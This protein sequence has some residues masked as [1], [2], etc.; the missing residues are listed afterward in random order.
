MIKNEG[1]EILRNFIDK[2]SLDN[3]NKANKNLRINRGHTIEGDYASD[4]KGNEVW[5]NYWT[6]SVKH[7][8]FVQSLNVLLLEQIRFHLDK[9]VMYHA[10]IV[11]TT[12]DMNTIR[13][14]VDTP[15]RFE[16]FAR[17]EKLLGIQCLIPLDNFN[18]DSGSTGFVPYSQKYYFDIKKCYS[19]KYNDYFLDN[20][21]QPDLNYGDVL[22]W[23]PKT[24]HSA[25]PNQTNADRKALLIFYCSKNIEEFLKKIDNVK[26]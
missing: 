6:D 25:I 8:A 11:C 2:N 14:H 1:W 10:D 19:G 17:E 22:L 12:K 3:F 16:E 23:H 24:L 5:A 7:T 15:Y 26:V 4:P 20:Y 9:P 18:I 13:P 21:V